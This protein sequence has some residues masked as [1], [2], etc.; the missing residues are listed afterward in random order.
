MPGDIEGEGMET[1]PGFSR[2]DLHIHSASADG[3]ATVEQILDYVEHETDLALIAITDHDELR[4]ALQ[5]RELAARRRY[6]F[7]V[8]VGMEITTL[9]GH[10]LAY[11]IERPIRMLLPLARTLELV[12]EQ[13]GFCIVPH[14]LSWLTWS[15]G[16]RALEGVLRHR[17]GG[18]EGVEVMNPNLAG[19]VTRA[20]ALRLNR[21]RWRLAECG[22][23]DAHTLDM[24]GMAYTLFPGHTADDFR[25]A[26]AQRTTRAGGRFLSLGEYRQLAQIAVAQVFKSWV[27]LP[28][29]RIGEALQRKSWP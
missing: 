22:G 7:Q 23:S 18:L 9:Q 5:A 3:M 4:G 28:G 15:V 21:Q 12:Q 25:K 1:P 13:G 16:R 24:I 8:L 14:P 6:R 19:Q 29:R 27:I 17:V 2:A 20:K 26:L 11:D 10:L